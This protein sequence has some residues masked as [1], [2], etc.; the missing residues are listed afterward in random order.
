MSNNLVSLAVIPDGNRTFARKNGISLKEGYVAGV[1]KAKESLKWVR[2]YS[3]LKFVSFYTLS[4]ENFKRSPTEVKVL[5]GLF[6]DEIERALNDEF[7]HKNRVKPVLVGRM[8][9]LPKRL[10]ELKVKLDNDAPE[11][12]DLQANFLVAYT[13]QTEIVDAAKRMAEA[14]KAGTLNLNSVNES[15]FQRFLYEQFPNPDLVIRTKNM[16]RLS[17]MLTYET[18]YSELRFIDKLWPE[19]EKSDLDAAVDQFY[20]TQRNFGK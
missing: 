2:D 20:S 16:H 7:F 3:D 14:Y 18:A 19:V 10:Q 17:G 4:L 5:L 1:E 15:S 13:G 9:L 12:S 6:A 8:D 11:E